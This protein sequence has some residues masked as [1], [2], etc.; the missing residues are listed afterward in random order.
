MDLKLPASISA[1]VSVGISGRK[2]VATVITDI[3][4]YDTARGAFSLIGQLPKLWYLPGVNELLGVV[5]EGPSPAFIA[6]SQAE[7]ALASLS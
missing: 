4:L 2:V 5:V 6:A 1:R 3:Y 7:R